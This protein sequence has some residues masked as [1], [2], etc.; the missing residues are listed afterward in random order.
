MICSMICAE[1]SST[2]SRSSTSPQTASPDRRSCRTCPASTDIPRCSPFMVDAD[3]ASPVA[4]HIDA[5]RDT[6][7]AGQQSQPC[8]TGT[9]TTCAHPTRIW[10]LA[11]FSISYRADW[12][13][14]LSALCL[15][16]YKASHDYALCLP[17]QQNVPG[18]RH[19]PQRIGRR[20]LGKERVQA[21]LQPGEYRPGPARLSFEV[22]RGEV[23]GI[24]GANGAGKTTLIKI[25]SGLLLPDAGLVQ[26]NGASRRATRSRNRSAM[27]R[28]TAGW[29]WNGS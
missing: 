13:Q 24:F 6:G 4:R 7:H 11:V 15:L 5:D 29:A 27:S 17:R 20:A 12:G 21:Y 28:P 26:V 2:W 25:L 18:L 3:G 22:E 8:R 1:I 19:R 16:E 9:R 10:I 14:I 23:F